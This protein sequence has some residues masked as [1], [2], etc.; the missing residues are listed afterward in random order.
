MLKYYTYKNGQ[1]LKM[2]LVLVKNSNNLDAFKSL[3]KKKKLKDFFSNVP[4]IIKHS[5]LLYIY[6]ILHTLPCFATV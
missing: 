1:W 2:I 3:K 5:P 6:H 4:G